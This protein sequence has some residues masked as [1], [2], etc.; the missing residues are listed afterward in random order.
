MGITRIVLETL[1]FV[2]Q[3]LRLRLQFLPQRMGLRLHMK[4]APPRTI[5][6]TATVTR[7]RSGFSIGLPGQQ[8]I[9]LRSGL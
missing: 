6:D 7:R 3:R 8:A 5:T 2:R 9:W 1:G 4:S